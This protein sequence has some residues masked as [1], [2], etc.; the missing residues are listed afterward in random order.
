MSNLKN[1]SDEMVSRALRGLSRRLPPPGLTTA[2]RVSASREL[3]RRSLGSAFLYWVERLH[4]EG[5]DAMRSL[6]LPVAGGV[7]SAVILLGMWVVPTYPVR[8]DNSF[9][10]P[11]MLTPN[12][13]TGTATEAAVK[14]TGPVVLAG[15]D[16]VVDITIDG[17]GRIV[18]YRVVSGAEDPGFRRRLENLLLFTEFVPA[19]AF[20]RP[21]AS[22]MRLTLTS[23]SVE[24]RG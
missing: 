9:D 14:A 3:R 5:S 11:T 4:R 23:S 12:S 18:E 1:A 24:V 22:R 16:V 15:G 20:G 7:F 10:V 6:A 21:G 19:T 17:R 8:A 2:L 13:W